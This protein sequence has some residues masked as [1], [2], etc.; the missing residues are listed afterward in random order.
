MDCFIDNWGLI[1]VWDLSEESEEEEYFLYWDIFGY[2][3]RD[4]GYY[5]A[6]GIFSTNYGFYI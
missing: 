3:G 1:G 6:T 2:F 5:F 4:I